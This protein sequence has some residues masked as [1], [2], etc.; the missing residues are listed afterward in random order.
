M[1]KNDSRG[2]DALA[3][4]ASDVGGILRAV[5][6]TSDAGGLAMAT[7]VRREDVPALTEGGNE[8]KKYLPAAAE[9]MEQQERWSVRGAF[10]VI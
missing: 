6:S 7:K 9:T 2:A 1:S 4:E 3:K 10:G 5:V 8:R